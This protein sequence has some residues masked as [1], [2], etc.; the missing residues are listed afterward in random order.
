MDGLERLKQGMGSHDASEMMG[1]SKGFTAGQVRLAE[2]F[3]FDE[4][5]G[6]IDMMRHFC[7]FR[8]LQFC[9]SNIWS[10]PVMSNRL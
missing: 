7:E 6:V 5:T 8:F 10:P 3:S 1:C 4:R 2:S 9:K